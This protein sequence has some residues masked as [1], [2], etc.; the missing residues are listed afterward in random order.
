VVLRNAT[1]WDL[2]AVFHETV[3]HQIELRAQTSVEK[4]STSRD[5]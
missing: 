3:T 4:E 2:E 1:F 5:R